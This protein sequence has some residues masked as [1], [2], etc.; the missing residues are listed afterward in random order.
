MK[1]FVVTLVLLLA[2]AQVPCDG[3]VTNETVSLQITSQNLTLVRETR[4]LKVKVG[5]RQSVQLADVPS[6]IDPESLQVRVQGNRGKFRI[7]SSRYR[8]DLITRKNLLDHFVGKKLSIVIRDPKGAQGALVTRRATLLA[9]NQRPIFL[10]GKQVYV[11]KV[12]ALWFPAIPR[13]MSAKPQLVWT[14]DNALK[15]PQQVELSYLAG[16][17]SWN[18]HY[19][20]VYNEGDKAGELTGW[21]T[22]SN[23]CGKSFRNAAVE[24]IAGR[25][26]VAKQPPRLARAR[27]GKVEMAAPE[28]MNGVSERPAFEYHLYR[29]QRLLD[30]PNQQNVQT[31]FLNARI[32]A[33]AKRLVSFGN[34]G[35]RYLGGHQG[36]EQKQP[37]EVRLEFPVEKTNGIDRPLPSGYIDVYSK[38]ADNR[39]LYIGQDR[40]DHTPV[41]EKVALTVGNAFDIMVKRKQLNVER[42][43][44]RVL[45]ISWELTVSNG[46][47]RDQQ[48]E[49][50]ETLPGDWRILDASEGY[51]QL[52][53]H[54]I[55]FRITLPAGSRQAIRYQVEISQA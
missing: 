31:S 39:L 28:R 27:Y 44:K 11:G 22:V 47:Q 6:T 3:A 45:R 21:V 52:D 51:E 13:G 5:T 46:K 48:V 38:S 43:G 34:G 7:L 20:L 10:I 14:V 29:I 12:E 17:I 18:A 4:T 19:A 35:D 2:F 53:A 33:V 41:G 40:I 36:A 55:R 30:L 25:I 8:Y 37:V 1:A 32:A 16:G 24:L 9:N 42:V 15:P 50:M 23:R 26:H 49:L 54:R